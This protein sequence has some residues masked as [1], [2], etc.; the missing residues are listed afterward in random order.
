MAKSRLAKRSL[1]VPRLEL[2]GAHMATNLAVNV[3]N[4]LP[5]V[6]VPS[7]HAWID[8]MVAL[9]WICGNGMYKQF[10][11]NRVAKIQAHPEV[12]WQYVPTY[13][14]P[15]DIASRGGTISKEWWIK[16]VRLRGCLQTYYPQ[17]SARLGHER[18]ERDIMVCKGRIQGSYP[19]YLPHDAVFTKK[20]I[21]RVH[22]ETL[23]GGVGITMAAVRECY[24]V[25]RLRCLVKKVRGDCWGCK[26]FRVRAA[27]VPVP[28][29]LP[30]DRTNPGTAFEV[31]G[32]DFAGPVKYKKTAKTEGKAY[33]A[34]FACSLSR[35]IYWELLQNLET[36]T[37]LL[38]LTK[39]IARRGRPRVIYSDNGGTFVKASEWLKQIRK[40]E[41]I[42]GLVEEYE[43]I[44]K[45]NISRAP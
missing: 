32:I 4:A 12:Q 30:K 11:A 20:L 38:S 27:T 24:C 9:H 15:A 40:D 7:I 5:K 43:I 18:T 31:V 45:F 17:T 22:C 35:A 16:R 2:V 10:V 39:Y 36:P 19:I 6:P 29:L 44:W 1:T 26:R 13:D 8:S 41:R 14:N 42:R 33:L 34:I 3:R 23:H 21:Q 37:F 25:P 28:G